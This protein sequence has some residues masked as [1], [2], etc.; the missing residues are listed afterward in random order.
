MNL[1]GKVAKNA[2]WIIG[3][4]IARATFGMVI[5]LL[6]ARYLGP[7]DYGIISYAS[8]LAIIS[9]APASKEAIIT[10]SSSIVFSITM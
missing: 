10:S 9:S 1:N 5:N 4:R 7:S 8:S 6:T 2:Y 3:C